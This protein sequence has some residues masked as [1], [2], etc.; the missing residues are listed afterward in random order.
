MKHKTSLVIHIPKSA[1]TTL[2]VIILNNYKK[3]QVFNINRESINIFGESWKDIDVREREQR[4]KE[5]FKNLSKKKRESYRV[6]IGHMSYG[7][8]EFFDDSEYFAVLR[9]PTDRIVS[10]Y[11]YIMKI[12]GHWIRLEMERQ[13]MGFSEFIRS[14]LSTELSN[15][16]SKRLTNTLYNNANE[17][18]IRKE[19]FE[20]IKQFKFI[21]FQEDYLNTLFLLKKY[22]GLS[23]VFNLHYNQSKQGKEKSISK[24]DK[25]F[26]ERNNSIDYDLYE[27]A[28][29]LYNGHKNENANF[30]KLQKNFIFYENFKYKLFT[31][32]KTFLE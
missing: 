27:R 1:G 2:N 3:E 15:G 12:E 16:M 8:H 17:A 19:I 6:V 10:L 30:L 9:D 11:N 23:A 7:W 14:N 24:N 13:G 31:K 22:M 26:L 4:V 28:Y 29:D 25:E 18:L 20:N 21:G 32:A 5:K